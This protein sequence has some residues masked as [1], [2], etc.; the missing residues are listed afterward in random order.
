MSSEMIAILA[1]PTGQDTRPPL[2][3]GTTPTTGA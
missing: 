2:I 1:I 3:D